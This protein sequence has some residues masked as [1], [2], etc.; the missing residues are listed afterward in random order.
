MPLKSNFPYDTSTS[1]N[2]ELTYFVFSYATHVTICVCVRLAMTCAGKFSFLSDLLRQVGFDAL[3]FGSCFNI[4]AHFDI[5]KNSFDGDKAKF[6]KYHQEVLDIAKDLDRLAKPAVLAQ[7]LISSMLLCVIGFQIVTLE[8]FYRKIIVVI[9]GFAVIIQLFTYALGGQ[10][11]MDK[12]ALVADNF[13][14]LDRDLLIIMARTQKPLKIKAGFYET[15]L[16]TFSTILSS[17]A[18]L[19]TLFQSLAE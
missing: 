14:Q 6:V 16:P 1:P 15:N 10:L 4:S 9:F 2:Y 17:A 18:S 5:L 7:F 11:V 19:I 3:F 12:A 13:Y 8:D